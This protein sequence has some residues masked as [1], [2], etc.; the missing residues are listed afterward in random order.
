MANDIP[1]IPFP[2]HLTPGVTDPNQISEPKQPELEKPT[3]GSAV[4]DEGWT[5]M[6]DPGGQ[7]VQVDNPQQAAMVG[8]VPASPEPIQGVKVA[9]YQR[10]SF[11]GTSG[12]LKTG[13]LAAARAA[14]FGVSD[15]VLVGSELMTPEEITVYREENPGADLIGAGLGLAGSALIPGGPVRAI[16]AAGQGARTAVLGALGEGG[17]TA[18]GR[19]AAKA[20]ASGAGTALE[21]AA[22]ASGNLVS[23]HALGNPNLTAQS[24]LSKVGVAGMLGFAFGGA[25][26]TVWN[27]AGEVGSSSKIGQRIHDWLEEA[28]GGSF[29]KAT[30]GGINMKRQIQKL[31]NTKGEDAAL[32]IGREAKELGLIPG[33]FPSSKNILDASNDLIQDHGPKLANITHAL[34]AVATPKEM[35]NW[36]RIQS[37]FHDDILDELKGQA[38]QQSVVRDLDNSLEFWGQKWPARGQAGKFQSRSMTFSELHQLRHE[39]GQGI[40]GASGDNNWHTSTYR[41]ALHSLYGI[42]NDE[43]DHTVPNVK[44]AINMY[45]EWKQLNRDYEVA[46]AIGRLAQHGVAGHTGNMTAGLTEQLTGGI[47]ASLGAAAGL[48]AELGEE[49]GSSL[50]HALEHGTL[51]GLIFGTAGHLMKKHWAS[52]SGNMY[53]AA[54]EALEKGQA[55]GIPPD[56]LAKLTESGEGAAAGTLAMGFASG[57]TVP[58][59]SR[60][61][62]DDAGFAGAAIKDAGKQGSL[63]NLVDKTGQ[64]VQIERRNNIEQPGEPGPYEMSASP[65]A[66]T[67]E[68]VAFLAQLE[69]QMKEIEHEVD[70]DAQKVVRGHEHKEGGTNPTFNLDHDSGVKLFKRRVEALQQLQNDPITLQAILQK[71]TDDWHD[72]APETAQAMNITT[73]RALTYLVEHVPQEPVQGPLAPRMVP[74]RADVAAFNRTW[75]SVD[76]PLTILKSAAAGS[77]TPD[78][79]DAV[80]KVY[81]ELY[82]Q[83]QNAVLQHLPDP[84]K[85]PIDYQQRLMLSA[86]LMQDM[87][88]T[89]NPQLMMANSLLYNPPQMQQMAQ[90]PQRATPARADK[91]KQS[92]RTLTD[93]QTA[94]ARTQN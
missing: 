3:S 73:A 27:A 14:T 48:G 40:Y 43:F 57:G 30:G 80:S 82:K 37:S 10:H 47:G 42:I 25:G 85:K 28:E 39:V 18:L 78:H 1:N 69:R 60:R 75:D 77:I 90:Q 62:Q 92:E 50:P 83:I 93:Q 41:K 54:R 17:A 89:L 68:K 63:A 76:R 2:G 71:Q 5:Y 49:A 16:S 33:A 94:M 8:Y 21:S 65:V 86:L 4:P 46:S 36:G 38:L 45:K 22:Y 19:V 51:T 70:L 59:I 66:N 58:Q 56:L 6:Q 13:A 23:E 31:M 87:D 26:G 35:P 61:Q 67:P 9:E 88:G 52:I 34:D 53:K 55:A 20:V 11:G 32:A 15:K 91:L 64:L 44:G 24:A 81:P 29:L 12:E 84:A 72:H 79:I 74:S 7:I